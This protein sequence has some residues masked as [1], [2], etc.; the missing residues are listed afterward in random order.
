MSRR[1]EQQSIVE[2]QDAEACGPDLGSDAWAKPKRSSGHK[3]R[4]HAEAASEAVQRKSVESDFVDAPITSVKVGDKD[5]ILH[6]GAN[7]SFHGH[8]G[9][10]DGMG[11]VDSLAESAI[12]AGVKWFAVTPHNH[13]DARN[14]VPPDDP[15]AKDQAGKRTV[16]EDPE[17]YAQ[18]LKDVE[19][20]SKGGKTLAFAGLEMGTISKT[21][22]IIA[23]DEPTLLIADLDG[24]TKEYPVR[25]FM[26]GPSQPPAPDGQQPVFH[27]K[28]KDGLAVI[29]YFRRNNRA[30]NLYLAH[31]EDG[32][33]QEKGFPKGVNSHHYFMDCFANQYEWSAKC[34][35]YY[36][37]IGA[38]QLKGLTNGPVERM[39]PKSLKLQPVFGYNDT[40]IR[41][42]M[43]IERDQ[44]YG[45]AA[46]R[47]AGMALL[48]PVGKEVDKPLLRQALG[49]RRSMVSTA[50]DDL[51]A[52]MIANDKYVMGNV[53]NPADI[54]SLRFKV[55]IGGK[56]DRKATY[57]VKLWA[58]TALGDLKTATVV[59][60]K[61]VTGDELLR[62]HQ[63][64]NFDNVKYKPKNGNTFVMEIER[65]YPTSNGKSE[66]DVA[67]ATTAIWVSPPE[68]VPA[69]AKGLISALRHR[70]KR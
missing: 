68:S 31:P 12:K 57:N 28:V 65:A 64:V 70:A 61:S 25:R 66:V 26:D 51:H 54:D 56:L 5:F 69:P 58:D 59:D 3:K 27:Y 4:A 34:G 45:D 48:V 7:C 8:Y 17:V 60:E 46:G 1:V 19:R 49:E 55:L 33:P 43:L 36:T 47:P 21:N 35:P 11:T 52:V 39:S 44:H 20:I 13:K 40:G 2:C 32:A 63:E 10:D 29:D 42:A 50:Y 9:H 67:A 37:G 41:L 16:V 15:R 14:G 6:G 53:I 24:N 38:I 30:K 23:I 22:H 18:L 62:N